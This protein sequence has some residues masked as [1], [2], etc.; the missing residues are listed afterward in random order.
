MPVNNIILMYMLSMFHIVDCSKVSHFEK[1]LSHWNYKYIHGQ[2]FS[3]SLMY[4]GVFRE[5][6]GHKPP[7]QK[8]PEHEP[9][10]K[11]PLDISPLGQKPPR[12]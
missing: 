2:G 6:S 5:V 12:L 4:R 1:L 8:P 3:V 10:T 7:G 11:S 9:P